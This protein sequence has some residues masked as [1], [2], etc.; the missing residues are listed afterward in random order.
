MKLTLGQVL[1]LS[2]LGLA[3]T[4]ALLFTIV[5]NESR[6]AIIESS[7][8]IR[9]EASREITERV[10]S[11]LSKAPDTVSAFQQQIDLGLVDPSNPQAVESALFALLLAKKDVSE[12]TFTR[13]EQTGFGE[14]G[15]MVLAHT[16][17]WQLSV[18]RSTDDLGAEHLWRHYVRQENGG[19]VSY[20]RILQPDSNLTTRPSSEEGS[21]AVGDPTSHLTFA[22]PASRDFYGHLLWSDLHWSQLDADQP[23]ESR[24]IEV[25]VQQTVEDGSDKFAGV[26]R[27]GLL[28]EKLDRAVQLKLT[29]AREPDPHRIF[30][31]DRDG[32]L[33]TRGVS[34]DRVKLSGED[35]R[36]APSDLA[37]EIARALADPKLRAV[38]EDEPVRS[39][40]F[41]HDGQEFLTTFR[42]LP[43]TQD[44]TVGIVVP[45]AFY[46]GKLVAMRNRLLAI[47]LGVM[48]LLVGAGI[49]VLRSVKRA[50]GQITRE[51]LKMNA[52][53]FSPAA[54][55]SAFRDVTQVLESL[56]KAKAAMR[57]MGKYA[58]VDLVRRLYRD[59]SEPVLGGELMEISIMFSDVKGFTTF[60]EQ[61]DP[62]RLAEILGLYL[63]ALSRIIQGETRGTIDKYI[64][65]AIMTIWNAPE[66][67]PD[68]PQLACLAALRCREATRSLAQSPEWR[69]FPAFE[70]RFGLHCAKALVGH[71]GARDRMNYTAIGDAINLASRLEGLNKQ[72]GTSI[73]ASGNIVDRANEAF[74]FR[75]LDV[76]A[77]KGKSDPITIYELLG[78]KGALD[79]CRQVV[80]AYETAFSAYAAGNFERALA[81]LQENA[82]DPPSAVLIERCKAFLQVPPPADWRG[83]Y[84]S[85]SK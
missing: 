17:R 69:E 84:I 79:Q 81:I 6:A 12:M 66:P 45:R 21:S 3:A 37:P 18:V 70:T 20:R 78:T 25:S 62:N 7:E 28:A 31:S 35:L 80:S 1:A 58:P 9:D 32:R 57:V 48:L 2:L 33:I 76:V 73:I 53:E 82:S 40:V 36:I 54:T 8:R 74:D 22:T 56:E 41:R 29:P 13:A 55:D 64:G 49:A 39:G 51:S 42:L 30:L 52:L 19:F 16:P 10:T 72:Y 24:E 43:G 38:D 47:S 15:G 67:I 68:H 83:I 14:D 50:Q 11:L 60:S 61:L 71:F 75:L 4:L 77:V 26:I 34:T 44:W 59:K 63:E 46:L 23:Q 5:L 27:V 85:A 65:D